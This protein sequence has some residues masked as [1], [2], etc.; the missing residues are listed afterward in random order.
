MHNTEKYIEETI[1]SITDQSFKE[2]QIIIIDDESTDDS[3]VKVHTLQKKHQNIELYCQQNQGPAIAR[4]NGMAKANGKYIMFLDSDDLLATNALQNLYHAIEKYNSDVVIGSY[5]SFN[6]SNEKGWY[7]NFA[8]PFV[9]MKFNNKS[10][11]DIPKLITNLPV[12]NKI[13]LRTFLEDNAIHFYKNVHLREDAYFMAEVFVSTEKISHI[14]VDVCFYRVRE[15]N[16][17]SLTHTINPKVFEDIVFISEQIDNVLSKKKFKNHETINRERY[18]TELIAI[19]F[20]LKAFMEEEN[21]D[22]EGVMQKLNTYLKKIDDEII[23]SFSF[24]TRLVLFSLKHAQYHLAKEINIE[25]DLSSIFDNTVF[26]N[27]QTIIDIFL[28]EQYKEI[29]ALQK[30]KILSALSLREIFQSLKSYIKKKSLLKSKKI[31]RRSYFYFIGR[32]ANFK[33]KNSNIWLVGE[34]LGTTAQDTGYH[35]FRYCRKSYP[36]KE[37]YFVTPTL[38]IFIHLK[39][40]LK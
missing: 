36:T 25:D 1:K 31:L 18:I 14:P 32:I 11:D 20:R 37:I 27:N 6:Q 13:Y 15:K 21:S 24:K 9:G 34:R 12:W 40:L 35:F 39:N 3:V 26:K 19:N 30:S 10:L 17:I 29:Q 8:K 23:S 38:C 33:T 4:N 28:R 2:I 16:D 22:F 7:H 5:R